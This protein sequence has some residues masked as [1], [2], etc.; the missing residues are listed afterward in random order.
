M[1]HTDRTVRETNIRIGEIPSK[2]V[3]F[4][5]ARSSKVLKALS[6]RGIRVV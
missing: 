4:I 5:L 3:A 2:R 1:M 6:I